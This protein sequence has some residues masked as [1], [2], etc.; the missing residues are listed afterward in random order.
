MVC[1]GALQKQRARWCRL[2]G[3]LTSVSVPQG[4]CGY[5]VAHH[6]QCVDGWM[7]GWMIDC[8]VK[9]FGVSGDLIKRYT[10]AAIYHIVPV[11]FNNFP[12][13]FVLSYFKAQFTTRL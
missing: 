9:C 13:L 7:N 1:K 11:I 5:I 12:T 3:S 4:S 2:Y 8:S 6:C 10:S